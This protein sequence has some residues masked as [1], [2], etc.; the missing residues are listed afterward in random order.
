VKNRGELHLEK[1]LE[2]WLKNENELQ[3]RGI[4]RFIPE[5][6]EKEYKPCYI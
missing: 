1:F 2:K 5:Q 3:K 6:C 4:E